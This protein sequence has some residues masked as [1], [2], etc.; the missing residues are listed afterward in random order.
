MAHF[1]LRAQRPE[2]GQVH[3][4][5]ALAD[6]IPAGRRTG[7]L[8]QAPE[9]RAHDQKAATQRAY[10]LPVR[11]GRRDLRRVQPQRA[12]AGPLDEATEAAQDERHLLNVIDVRYVL[13]KAVVG[14]QQRRRH[15]AQSRVLGAADLH[16]ARQ[17]PATFEDERLLAQLEGHQP[18]MLHPGRAGW[19]TRGPPAALL[20]RPKAQERPL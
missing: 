3:V 12:I 8:A 15:R 6:D 16:R 11:T 17:A 9:Q 2:A 14:D 13:E 1:G 5:R 7:R 19:P 18:L 10:K 20:D 4:D